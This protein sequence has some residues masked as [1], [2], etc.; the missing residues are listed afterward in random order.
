MMLDDFELSHTWTIEETEAKIL[1]VLPD[2]Y[3]F[4]CVLDEQYDQFVACI[5]DMEGQN[6]WSEFSTVKSLLLLTA[7]SKAYFLRYPAKRP[8][9]VW[10]RARAS[11]GNSPIFINT[12]VGKNAED[13]EDLNPD[14]ILSVYDKYTEP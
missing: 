10:S 11:R 13:P 5:R 1:A 3:T 7:Y 8:S 9:P 12:E 6:I 2:G 4:D 14:E